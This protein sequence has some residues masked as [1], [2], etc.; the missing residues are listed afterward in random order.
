MFGER[1]P[2]S[3]KAPAFVVLKTSV[4]ACGMSGDMLLTRRSQRLRRAG[5]SPHSN[6]ERLPQKIYRAL[7][8]KILFIKYLF[9]FIR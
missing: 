5:A 9:Y 2:R 6:R 8:H 7:M 1:L 3:A 4:H